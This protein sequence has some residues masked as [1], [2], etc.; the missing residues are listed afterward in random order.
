MF[1]TTLN[2][3]NNQ[4]YSISRYTCMQYWSDHCDKHNIRVSSGSLEGN[5]SSSLSLVSTNVPYDNINDTSYCS[6]RTGI[7]I[8][9]AYSLLLTCTAAKFSTS[10]LDLFAGTPGTATILALA[11]TLHQFITRLRGNG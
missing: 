2:L 5:K 6:C 1:F 4:M 8:L 11:P 9:I 7:N 10:P 3:A